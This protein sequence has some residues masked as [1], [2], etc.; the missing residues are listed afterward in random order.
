MVFCP[1]VLN[2]VVM[3]CGPKW[4]ELWRLICCPHVCL[5]VCTLWG[6]GFHLSVHASVHMCLVCV[7]FSIK[8]AIA[9][10][11]WFSTLPKPTDKPAPHQHDHQLLLRLKNTSIT[12]LMTHGC[13]FW[14][15]T[16][17]GDLTH[18]HTLTGVSN[19]RCHRATSNET[20]RLQSFT[21]VQFCL[22][23]IPLF[24]PIFFNSA[25]PACTRVREKALNTASN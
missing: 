8:A 23:S 21:S 1:L 12:L 2:L 20:P 10:Q 22:S 19:G 24:F 25:S 9:Q 11:A 13:C 7:P 3:H 17:H 18:T 4:L 16:S 14:L 6:G 5:C 15:N